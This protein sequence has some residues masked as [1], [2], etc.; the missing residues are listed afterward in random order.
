MIK[1]LRSPYLWYL[2]YVAVVTIGAMLSLGSSRIESEVEM[3]V[4]AA[5]AMI[6]LYLRIIGVV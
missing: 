4:I 2:L 6:V 1:V 3:T 5:V